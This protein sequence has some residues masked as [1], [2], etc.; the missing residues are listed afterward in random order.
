LLAVAA[1]VYSTIRF[2]EA[3]GLWRMRR[4]AEWF[5][6]LSGGV[7]L[8]LEIYELTHHATL[9]KAVVLVINAAIVAY[10]IYF[11]WSGRTGKLM[12]SAP[13]RENGWVQSE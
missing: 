11:R 12:R 7:Y 2:I 1:L 3:F 4:W 9:V 13:P 10:L 6:I 8:P 5:A